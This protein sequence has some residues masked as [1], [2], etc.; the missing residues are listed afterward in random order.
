MGEDSQ[1]PSHV[2]PYSQC[3]NGF[4]IA[5]LFLIGGLFDIFIPVYVPIAAITTATVLLQAATN[6]KNSEPML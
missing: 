1:L 6:S 2:V 5:R 3:T 4:V